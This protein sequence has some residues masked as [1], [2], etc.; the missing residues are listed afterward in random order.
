MISIG[1][2]SIILTSLALAVVC[3]SAR[4]QTS[5]N[6]KKDDVPRVQSVLPPVA[7]VSLPEIKS[8]PAPPP[9]ASEPTPNTGSANQDSG[10]RIAPAASLPPKVVPRKVT[11]EARTTFD[12]DKAVLKPEGKKQLDELVNKLSDVRV[13]KITVVGHADSIGTRKYNL[14]L[15]QKRADTV[16]AYLINKGLEVNVITTEAKGDTQPIV[17]PKQCKGSKKKRIVCLAPNRRM[18]L[19]LNGIQPKK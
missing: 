4:S 18:E 8:R 10:G 16:K 11:L 9:P 15:S 19:E 12:F 2:I 6:P 13:D 17:S 3:G 5:P 7:P 14:K 1:K